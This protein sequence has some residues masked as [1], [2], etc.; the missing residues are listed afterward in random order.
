MGQV[1]KKFVIKFMLLMIIQ[2]KKMQ[3]NPKRNHES[4]KK[5][6]SD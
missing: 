4:F 2:E 6:F 5:I 3:K 1:A